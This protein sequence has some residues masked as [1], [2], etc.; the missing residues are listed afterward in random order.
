MNRLAKCAFVGFALVPSMASAQGA[1]TIYKFVDESG[2]VTY[3]NSPIKG[4]TKVN[5]EPLTVLQ[6]SP[7][8]AQNSVPAPRAIPVAKVTSVPSPSS[9]ANTVPAAF[10][11]TAVAAVA[12]AAPAATPPTIIAALDTGERK[13]EQTQQRLADA[14]QRILQSEIQAEEKSL[15][16]ARA[17]LADE[18]RRSNEVRTMRASFAATATSATPTKPLISPEVRAEIE[19]HFERVRNLQDQV[20]MHENSIGSLRTALVASK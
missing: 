12:T 6:S 11:T 8:A 19:R 4:G 3:A 20:S 16:A 17:A 7:G 5:L 18:Q 1:Q 14:R 9:A 15:D 10:A 13:H 2:R